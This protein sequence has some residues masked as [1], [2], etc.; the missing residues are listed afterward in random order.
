MIKTANTLIKTVNSL[1]LVSLT[2]LLS[3]TPSVAFSDSTG[4]LPSDP[5]ALYACFHS[6]EFNVV[7]GLDV[8]TR[9]PSDYG[10]PRPTGGAS[11]EAP[12]AARLSTG[13]PINGTAAP[14][15][16]VVTLRAFFHSAAFNASDDLNV[17]GGDYSSYGTFRPESRTG[18][19]V[20]VRR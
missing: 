10:T 6:A 3:A 15:L 5:A 17:Y 18:E 14:E 12:V 16:D 8:Y 4:C 9:D 1:T 19:L 7:D 20:K 2:A 11:E 13:T